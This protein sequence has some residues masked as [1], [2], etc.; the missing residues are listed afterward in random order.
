M[1]GGDSG[2]PELQK[3]PPPGRGLQALTELLIDEGHLLPHQLQLLPQEL[4]AEGIVQ[5][6]PTLPAQPLASHLPTCLLMSPPTLLFPSVPISCPSYPSPQGLSL[7]PICLPSLPLLLLLPHVHSPSPVSS[8]PD[9]E[10]P[11]L[12]ASL[13]LAPVTSDLPY[14]PASATL[15]LSAFQLPISPPVS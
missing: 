1:G 8:P 14:S 2:G 5:P 7:P 13:C 3:N 6:R 11:I 10:L 4:L 9:L 15:N 12:S